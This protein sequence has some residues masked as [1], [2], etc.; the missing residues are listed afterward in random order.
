MK[1]IAIIF[2]ISIVVFTLLGFSEEPSKVTMMESLYFNKSNYDSPLEAVLI[3]GNTEESTASSIKD[4]NAVALI[5]QNNGIKVTKFYDRNTNWETIKIAAKTANFFVYSGHGS[6]M[7]I[8]GKTGGLCL[9]KMI[10]TKQIL[11]ELQLK[12]NAVVLFKSV[13]GGAGSSAVDSKDIGIEEAATRVTDYA[14][15]FFII[16]ASCYYADNYGGGIDMFLTNFLAGKTI[17]ECYETTT[18][19]PLVHHEI[20]KPFAPDSKKQIAISSNKSEGVTTLYTF[21]NG[22]TTRKKI[23]SFKNY[24]IAYVGNPTFTIDDLTRS[25]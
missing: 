2:T 12:K 20:A 1:N 21:E 3:V 10:S 22:K 7:G 9:N 19:M 17:N 8:N 5:F 13:C 15:P 4:M 16:G 14:Q 6:T 11:E 24:N 18:K 23:P 25:R